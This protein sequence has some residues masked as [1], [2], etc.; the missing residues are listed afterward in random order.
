MSTFIRLTDY[1]SENQ[2]RLAL[3]KRN[4][5][6]RVNQNQFTMIPGMP[7]AYWVSQSVLRTFGNSENISS[8]ARPRIGMRTGDNER[9]LRYWFEISRT[10]IDLSVASATEAIKSGAKWFPYNKGGAFRR[11]YGNSLIVVLWENNGYEIKKN[12]L[13]NYPQL[14]WDNLSWKISNEKMFFKAAVTWSFV[15]SSFAVRVVP[16]GHLFDVG[17]S[18]AFPESEALLGV[19]AYLC[20]STAAF[21][22]GVLNPTLNFQISD[23]ANLPWQAIGSA[24]LQVESIARNAVSISKCDWDLRET[25]WDF[26]RSPLLLNYVA[27][28]VFTEIDKNITD[29]SW[30]SAVDTVCSFADAYA[31]YITHWTKEFKELHRLEEENNRIFIDLYGLQDE[32]SPEVPYSEVTILQD[33]LD[34][35]AR[36]RGEIV[37]NKKEVLRQF[38]S[39]GVGCIFGRYSLDEEGLILADAGDTLDTYLE[40]IP[41]P[42]LRPD[43]SGILPITEDDDFPDDLPSQ[44]RA[45]LR[46]AFSNEHYDENVQFLEEGLG[47]DLR[48]YFLKHFYKDHVK[49]YK[50]RPIY[51]LITSPKGSL[52]ALIYLHRYNRDTVNRFLND[53]LRPY[54]RKLEARRRTAEQSLNSGGLSGSERT[55]AR[56][57]IDRISAALEELSVWERDVVRP[58]AEQRVELDLDDGVK[59]N[60]GKL[61]SIL[62]TL[63]GLNG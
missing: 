37:F 1:V 36:E 22:A 25:S 3:L 52:R 53:Y 32:L 46:A 17:G 57:D 61:G 2:K 23:V 6:F 19:S 40:R 60:Y 33:E 58:L 63:K 45:F 24:K 59:V 34:K 9:F 49:R 28:P 5:V 43:E 54:Q 21:F 42:R 44:F 13:Q 47:R 50:K 62:E 16:N 38:V 11:W 10:G 31:S 12:T 48:S 14:S 15:G 18:C 41:E 26:R 7:I 30:P 56:K 39:Y 8:V 20:S 35:D 27:E 55:K 4:V 51:W 29:V